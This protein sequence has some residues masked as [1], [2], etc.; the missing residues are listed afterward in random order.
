MNT[1]ALAGLQTLGAQLRSAAAWGFLPGV[2]ATAQQ[3][4]VVVGTAIV[5]GIRAG[6]QQQTPA[7]LAEAAGLAARIAAIMRAALAIRSPSQVFMEIGGQVVMGLAR[8]IDQPEPIAAALSGLTQGLTRQIGQLGTDMASSG[9][10]G[11]ATTYQITVQVPVEVLRE[12][13]RLQTHAEQFGEALMQQLRR[14][15]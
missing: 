9:G 6:I 8:G 14:L 15:R 7:L 12:E 1:T 3:S 11:G 5:N 2:A 10:G 4:A 13:G